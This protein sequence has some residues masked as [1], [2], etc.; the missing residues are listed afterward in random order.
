MKD[1][2]ERQ[3]QEIDELKKALQ[4]VC[5]HI[6]KKTLAYDVVQLEQEKNQCENEKEDQR[7][8]IQELEQLL[9]EERQTYEHNR[10]SVNSVT[11]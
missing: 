11:R 5:R 6:K 1:T 3:K 9:E 10:Q 2:N 7:L 4:K 8:Q